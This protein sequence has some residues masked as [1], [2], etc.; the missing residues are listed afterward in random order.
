MPTLKDIAERLDL[1]VMA[2]SKALR[3]APDISSK[4]KN[5]VR[6]EAERIGYVPDASARQLRGA[7]SGTIGLI[8]PLLHE[9]S[10][11]HLF[12][13]LQE[14]AALQ[15]LDVFVH[16]SRHNPESE[17]QGMKR[18]LS[19]RVEALFIAPVIQL[20]HRSPL[21]EIGNRTGVPVIFL[22]NYPADIDQFP[23]ALRVVFDDAGAGRLA[24]DHL[25]SLGHRDILFFSGPPSAPASSEY[26]RGFKGGLK[27]HGLKESHER[28]FACGSD[29]IGGRQTMARA[30]SENVTFTA[31]VCPGDLPAIG[32][33]EELQDQG[34]TIPGDISVLGL[35]DSSVAET[36]GIPLTTLHRPNVELGRRA[37]IHWWKNRNPLTRGT[38]EVEREQVVEVDL[39]IRDSSGPVA[40]A[41]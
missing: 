1:S 14:A 35:G 16:C 33:C 27:E 22:E 2:V 34:Y 9:A 21:L 24:V 29:R 15:G 8:L 17:I 36:A 41:T 19:R 6:Q 28:V 11:A 5:R 25:V 31:V 4:T 12:E 40:G 18:L 23:R 39:T 38:F 10:H 13:G 30:L 37:F 20:H 7:S 32:V 26:F 3:D